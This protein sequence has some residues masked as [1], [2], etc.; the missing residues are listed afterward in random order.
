MS[1]CI[2]CNISRTTRNCHLYTGLFYLAGIKHDIG[3]QT[4]NISVCVSC[5]GDVGTDQ[6]TTLQDLNET[7]MPYAGTNQDQSFL[8]VSAS[9]NQCAGYGVGDGGVISHLTVQYLEAEKKQLQKEVSL[10][11]ILQTT[12]NSP[13]LDYTGI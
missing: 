9:M 8:N 3:I 13:L 5:N 12:W 10:S 2:S 1:N 7:A 6:N 4:T 11:V